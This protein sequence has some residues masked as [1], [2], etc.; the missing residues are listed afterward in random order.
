MSATGLLIQTN[1][2]SSWTTEF[3]TYQAAESISLSY[4]TQWE[5]VSSIR[6][7]EN[8]S[9]RRGQMYQCPSWKSHQLPKP[10]RTKIPCLVTLVMLWVFYKV[11][12]KGVT[13]STRCENST[14]E[15]DSLRNIHVGKKKQIRTLTNFFRYLVFALLRKGPLCH[16]F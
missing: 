8:V 7:M 14:S 9:I 5:F 3:S 1:T 4:I 2:P 6:M 10:L 13:D 15:Y 11:T 12:D 16:I